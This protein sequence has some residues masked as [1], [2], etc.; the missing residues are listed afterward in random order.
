MREDIVA[1]DKKKLLY[2][3]QGTI[4]EKRKSLYKSLENEKYKEWGYNP[5]DLCHII[6]LY[7][8]AYDY[9]AKGKTFKNS[10]IPPE[11]IRKLCIKYKTEKTDLSEVIK[12]AEDYVSKIQSLVKEIL[13][14]NDF[15][16]DK[17]TYKKLDDEIYRI[18]ESN[19][20]PFWF[21]I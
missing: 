13:E 4:F 15:K 11:E 7:Y 10:L 9:F 19:L 14:N 2:S 6:R 18:V 8:L 12:V 1:A 5:K 17:E 16:I 21:L 20:S 3:I